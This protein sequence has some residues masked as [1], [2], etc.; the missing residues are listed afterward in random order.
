MSFED[1]QPMYSPGVFHV[2]FVVF[3]LLVT[4]LPQ[5]II[6]TE[7]RWTFFKTTKMLSG[8]NKRGKWRKYS[9][10]S[11]LLCS[12]NLDSCKTRS[13]SNF[14][15]LLNNKKCP[16]I[17]IL[18]QSSVVKNQ[19]WLEKTVPAPSTGFGNEYRRRSDI[20]IKF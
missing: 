16:A 10:P 7:F 13:C 12:C 14:Q 9:F 18:L 19:Q 5:I 4:Y 3:L 20:Y 11:Y 8:K 15:R 1:N 17:P 6:S 2:L